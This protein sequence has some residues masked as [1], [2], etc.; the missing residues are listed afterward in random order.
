MTPRP[1]ASRERQKASDAGREKIVSAARELLE[2]ADGETFSIDAVARRAGTARM[3]VYNQFES[4][5]GLLEAVFDMLASNGPMA[6]M[7]DVFREPD[8]F[9][10]LDLVVALFADFW[11]GH[12]LVYRSLRAAAMYDADLAAGMEQRNER[13]R[14]ALTEI[15]ARIPADHPMPI[16]REEAVR[17]LF[18][19]LSFQSFDAIAGPGSTPAEVAPLVQKVAALIVG[20]R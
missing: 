6:R 7:P 19:L 14:R 5:A 11:T 8:P 16:A 2:A 17:V 20:A 18:S 10:A 15:I 3:T 4:K 12:R 1:Y 9:R 13:R